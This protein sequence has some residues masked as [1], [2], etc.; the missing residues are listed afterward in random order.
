MTDAAALPIAMKGSLPD[1]AKGHMSG[2]V[3]EGRDDLTRDNYAAL[4][5]TRWLKPRGNYAY[6]GNLFDWK[7]HAPDL[8]ANVP[9]TQSAREAYELVLATQVLR[10]G[11]TPSMPASSLT[12]G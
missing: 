11:A 8:G 3:F 1:L 7:S 4:D 2:N 10:S 5:F 9:A 6:A 12:C